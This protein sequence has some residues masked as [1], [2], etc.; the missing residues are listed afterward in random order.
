MVVFGVIKI[1]EFELVLCGGFRFVVMCQ[2]QVICRWG[3]IVDIGELGC[4][5]ICVLWLSIG[6]G[7][8][9]KWGLWGEVVL[10]V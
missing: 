10:V 5:V 1:F 6:K 7:G 9:K 3:G 2:V 8:G 4:V